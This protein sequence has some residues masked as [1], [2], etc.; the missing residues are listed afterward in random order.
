MPHKVKWGRFYAVKDSTRPISRRGVVNS[1]KAHWKRFPQNIVAQRRKTG[2]LPFVVLLNWKKKTIGLKRNSNR[3]QPLLTSKKT[4]GNISDTTRSNR[5][6]RSGSNLHYSITNCF[7]NTSI[8]FL[9]LPSL[10]ILVSTLLRASL[11]VDPCM[12][13][14][15]PISVF[16]A[17]LMIFDTYI[18]ACL[19]LFPFPFLSNSSSF[20]PL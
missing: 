20:L 16:F 6:K 1:N 14:Y 7:F 8:S 4:L 15:L 2:I 18:S 9:N 17:L 19:S 5:R 11:T 13:K 12:P 3:R 10:F